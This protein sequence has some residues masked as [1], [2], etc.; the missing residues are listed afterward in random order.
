MSVIYCYRDGEELIKSYLLEETL[1][2]QIPKW[3]NLV[4]LKKVTFEELRL[5]LLDK[6]SLESQFAPS[7]FYSLTN[8]DTDT[9]HYSAAQLSLLSFEY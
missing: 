5:A 1:I 8:T 6:K 3:M 7:H 9:I 2:L 4:S